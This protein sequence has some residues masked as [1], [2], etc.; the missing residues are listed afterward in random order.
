M[1]VLLIGGYP[2]GHERPFD[3][4]TLSGKRLKAM[5]EEIEV[6]ASYLDLWNTEKEEQCGQIDEF[7][8]SIIKHHLS[9]GVKCIALGKW[10]HKRLALQ[11]VSI[12]HL[13]HPAS[14]RAI[15]RQRLKE[16]LKILAAGKPE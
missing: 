14:R 6:D 11:Q 10:V 8:I 13:P 4:A 15:D 1:K 16:G 9:E 7:L 3:P 5:V 2:K 12:P